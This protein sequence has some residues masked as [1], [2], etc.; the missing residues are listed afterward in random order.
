MDDG[1]APRPSLL[2]LSDFEKESTLGA[3][4]RLR[5]YPTDLEKRITLVSNPAEK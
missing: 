3:I 4:A 1:M 5:L 2:M